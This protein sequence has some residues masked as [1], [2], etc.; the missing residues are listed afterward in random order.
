[1][2]R[3]VQSPSNDEARALQK[4]SKESESWDSFHNDPVDNIFRSVFPCNKSSSKQLI[5]ALEP[6]FDFLPSVT[7]CKPGMAGVLMPEDVYVTLMQCTGTL[8]RFFTTNCAPNND[9]APFKG[10]PVF[11]RLNLGRNYA[12]VLHYGKNL[13]KLMTLVYNPRGERSREVCFTETTW[14]HLNDMKKL[15]AHILVKYNSY[16]PSALALYNLVAGLVRREFVTTNS[17]VVDR[18]TCYELIK[19]FIS[20]LTEIKKE[21]EVDDVHDPHFDQQRAVEEIKLYCVGHFVDQCNY[22]ADH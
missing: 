12:A 16:A 6:A 18:N 17:K 1:M 14:D 11:E 2:I 8:S 13:M 9:M 15:I 19:T 7:I 3:G 20:N 10:D 5:V 4:A 22:P 21:E